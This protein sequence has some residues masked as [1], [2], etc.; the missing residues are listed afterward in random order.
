MKRYTWLWDATLIKTKGESIIGFCYKN[1]VNVLYLQW[2]TR[3]DATDY[4]VFIMK[5]TRMGLRVHACLGERTWYDPENFAIIEDKLNAIDA[6]QR[7]VAWNSQ[8]SGIHF[9]IEPHTLPEWKTD[10]LATVTKWQTTV[11]LYTKKVREMG[12]ELS[13]SVPFSIAKTPARFGGDYYLSEF[14]MRQHDKVVVMAY[15]NMT[16]GNDSIW[17]HSLPLLEQTKDIMATEA[18][19]IAV[20]TKESSEGD[21]LTFANKGKLQLYEALRQID[22]AGEESYVGYA[23]HAIH[24]VNYWM[25]LPLVPEVEE[26]KQ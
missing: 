23:G 24:A 11:Q 14:M 5:A 10:N 6:Y 8:F 19:V 2:S 13:A 4:N 7:K 17:E 20:E 18:V 22:Y 9:D 26:K 25:D 15:R 3:V 1:N 12:L 21:K 16:F